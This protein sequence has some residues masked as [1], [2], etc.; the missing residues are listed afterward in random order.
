MSLAR[1]RRGSIVTPSYNQGR[2]I[3]ESIKS[4]LLHGYPSL[5]LIIVDG[6]SE[7]ASVQI[8]EQHQ[9][10]LKSW[11]SE[12]RSGPESAQQGIPVCDR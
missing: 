4:V 10:W 12:K 6:G 9:R 2:F 8:I 7:D 5:D 1:C 11:I 3:E